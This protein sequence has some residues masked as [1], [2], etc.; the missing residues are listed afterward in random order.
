M[1]ANS[2]PVTGSC[3]CGGVTYEITGDPMMQLQCHCLNCQKSSGAGHNPIAVYTDDQVK[4][5]GKLTEFKYKGDSGKMATALFCPTCGSQMLGRAEVMPGT[6]AVRV[7]TMED[8][9]FFAPQIAVYEKRKRHWD[10]QQ[11]QIPGFPMM[12]PMPGQS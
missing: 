2:K 4:V 6:I 3:S 11:A 8:S 7:G 5:M 1:P 12:P 9:A 10:Q